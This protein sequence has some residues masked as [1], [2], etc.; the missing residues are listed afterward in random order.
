[1][2]LNHCTYVTSFNGNSSFH[3]F[4]AQ[5]TEYYDKIKSINQRDDIGYD[6]S[7]ILD[8]S[9]IN[10]LTINKG[11][12]NTQGTCYAVVNS[13]K[14]LPFCIFTDL[15]PLLKSTLNKDQINNA[16]RLDLNFYCGL[17]NT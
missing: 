8:W 7:F 12:Y 4:T 10:N 1:M 9:R 16:T 14:E 11:M 2:K 6:L 5:E 3:R 13:I 17:Y 15:S